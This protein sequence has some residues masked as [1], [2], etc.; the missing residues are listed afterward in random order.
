MLRRLCLSL[1]CVAS[2]PRSAGASTTSS[3]SASQT[4]PTDS[5]VPTSGDIV[6][7]GVLRLLSTEA[8]AECAA[9]CQKGLA[10]GFGVEESAIGCLCPDN[11]SSFRRQLFVTPR[12]DPGSSS[13]QRRLRGL[14]EMDE[15]G[16]GAAFA[17]R[18]QGG[19]IAGI[20]A[21]E[22]FSASAIVVA[23]AFGV[24][25]SEVLLL[26]LG[27]KTRVDCLEGRTNSSP[28]PN[29]FCL[30]VPIQGSLNNSDIV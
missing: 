3:T 24:D 13:V 9:G 6:I 21:I 14:A 2:I 17:A 4:S 25:Q 30:W 28:S 18:V 20:D 16:V 29:I 27:A 22:L 11:T 26:C 1:V 19:V 5:I 8:L 7:N 12:G 10:A 15:D 23:S